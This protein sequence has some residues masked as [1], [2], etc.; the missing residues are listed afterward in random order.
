M[1]KLQV[2]STG[3]DDGVNMVFERKASNVTPKFCELTTKRMESSFAKTEVILGNTG[4]S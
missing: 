1:N 3:F 2:Q 4:S